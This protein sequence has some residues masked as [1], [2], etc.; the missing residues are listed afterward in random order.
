VA[1]QDQFEKFLSD[2]EPSNTTKKNAQKAHKG[3][4]DFLW[5]HEEFKEVL[6]EVFLSGSYRRNTA[7]RPRVKA[8]VTDRPDVDVI[9][10][11]D[12][13]LDADPEEVL[14]FLCKVLREKFA[15]VRKQGRSAGIRSGAADMDVVPI[16]A[17]YGMESTLY[18]PDRK[19]EQ[20]RET[21][22]VC[23]MNHF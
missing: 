12:Y 3:V 23:L 6:D 17:P 16:I 9:V 4:R 21:N 8:G 1:T 22:R 5:G 14:D 19:L 20:W 15:D 11:M 18:I 13:G 10:V 7:V 2:I